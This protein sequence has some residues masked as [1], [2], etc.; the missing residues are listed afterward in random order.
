MNWI[1]SK[2]TPLFY[3]IL[4][5]GGLAI[6]LYEVE[7]PNQNLSKFHWILIIPVIL[8]TYASFLL[9]SFVN[10]GRLRKDQITRAEELWPYDYV[11]FDPKHCKT[12]QIDR[13]ARSKHC[14]V[15]NVCVLKFDHHCIWINGCVGYYNY[16]YFLLFLVMTIS[17]CFYGTYL[18]IQQFKLHYFNFGIENLVYYDEFGMI[19]ASWMQKMTVINIDSFY[20]DP[21]LFWD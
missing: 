12:C 3:L 19:N 20:Y 15:C 18:S 4:I 2:L 11:L 14:S 10:P 17:Y 21:N 6:F 8:G 1:L 5:S 9:V 13:P 7:I 16:R